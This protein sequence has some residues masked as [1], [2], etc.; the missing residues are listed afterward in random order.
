MDNAFET[1]RGVVNTWECDEMGHM[2]VRYY[3]ARAMD[4]L[5][6]LSLA[7]GLEPSELRVQKQCLLP[8][9]QHLRFH[10]EVHPGQPIV[11]RG[12]IV[13]ATP[14]HIDT[15]QEMWRATDDVLCATVRTR[16]S[17]SSAQ[18]V[19]LRPFSERVRERAE[20]LK[21]DVPAH[22]LPRGMTLD[23]PRAPLTHEDAHKLGL[24]R[25]YLG[26]LRDED[27][28]EH[29]KMRTE[30]FMGR[31]SDGVPHFF[32]SLGGLLRDPHAGVGGAALE[33]RLVY[34]SFPRLGDVLE[35]RS[36]LKAQKAKATHFCHFMFDA[37][38]GACV[39]SSEAVAVLFD[40]KQR[41]AIAPPPEQLERLQ[42]SEIAGLGI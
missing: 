28:D 14:E 3:V 9:E 34:R 27:C 1:Y 35:I 19:E 18:I 30:S 11:M 38:T 26:L 41:K 25:I 12:G 7:L 32:A 29:G 33:Y 22:G 23:P 40:M 39:M 2:N 5:G 16:V 17:L 4:G 8:R 31:I 20:G 10:R 42:K 6:S 36:G 13:L 24:A 37:A 15:Y 21:V